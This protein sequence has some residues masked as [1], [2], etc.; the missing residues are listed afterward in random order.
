MN[1]DQWLIQYIT[2]HHQHQ[3][4]NFHSVQT[5]TLSLRVPISLSRQRIM[6]QITLVI[7]IYSIIFPLLFTKKQGVP[8]LVTTTHFSNNPFNLYSLEENVI[9]I[10]SFS[11]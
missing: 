10:L 7:C 5:C 9:C 6:I 11:S 8:F 2:L 4:V 3:H 1:V